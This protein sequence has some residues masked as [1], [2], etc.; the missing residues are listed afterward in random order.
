MR[1]I[2][3][4]V[5]LGLATPAVAGVPETVNYQGVLTESGSPVPDGAYPVTFRLYD[6][7]AGGSPLWTE[8]LAVQTADG[9]FSTVLGATTPLGLAFDV[10]LWL[11]LSVD[12]DPEM[13]PRIELT[14]VPYAL[15][16]RSLQDGAELTLDGLSLPDGAQAGYVLTS[17][18]TGVASWQPAPGGGGGFSLPVDAT[19]AVD[20]TAFRIT[21]TAPAGGAAAFRTI[22][23]LPA[24]DVLGEGGNHAATFRG[25][26]VSSNTEVVS[27]VYDTSATVDAT[28]LYVENDGLDFYGVAGDFR[29][30]WT[31][32]RSTVA[33]TGNGVYY[34]L[35]TTVIGGTGVNYGVFAAAASGSNNYAGYFTGP[36]HVN[37]TLS[38]TAGAFRIDHPLDPGNKYLQHS[39]VES[40]D[41]MNVYNGNATLDPDGTAQVTLPRWFE[42]L[43]RDFRYQL[44]ALGAP[45]P[46]LHVAGEI[47]GNAFTIAGGE[48]GM[49]VSW[50][51]TGI[52]QDAHARAHRIE[53]EL[54]KPAHDRG[55]YLDPEAHGRPATLQI[56]R[57]A[58]MQDYA[59]R[60]A[61]APPRRTDRTDRP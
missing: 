10:P 21:N 20:E 50:Q 17:D 46:N 61:E 27:V 51:V 13:T 42:A 8:T 6:V 22:G 60:R 43:N 55:R 9:V 48:P 37:G 53:V 7:D 31:G 41:M 47:E 12:A 52:R 54:D 14:A 4:L 30:G 58:K 19:H 56:G 40:P 28:A 16:A 1:S 29:A 59:R 32:L 39:F 15:R 34:G 24:L 23:S 57:D 25:K 36:V 38:K 18:S 2:L 49:R 45:G 44:T 35:Y 11:G 3:V 5:A 33:P 26:F